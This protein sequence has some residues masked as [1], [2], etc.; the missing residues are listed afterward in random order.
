MTTTSLRKG[1]V[2]LAFGGLL[3]CS[4]W[5]DQ[6]DHGTA[7]PRDAARFGFRLTEVSAACGIDFRH[8]G[9]T[10]DPLIRNVEP[11]VAALGASVSVADADADGWPDLYVTNSAFGKPNALYRNRGDGGAHGPG[12]FEDVAA[13][14]G[15][16]DCNREGE[17]VS[18]GF[19]NLAPVVDGLARQE[20]AALQA[21]PQG[22][23]FEQLRDVVGRAVV[24]SDVV[25]DQDVGVIELAGGARLLR[26]ANDSS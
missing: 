26:K 11:H 8:H 10:L 5:L 6:R 9:P 19:G 4:W 14:A 13:A 2:C 25:Y 1:G 3:A 23:A 21:T 15:V 20:R 12:T 22:L 7:S 24:R 16:A 17:G 18:M